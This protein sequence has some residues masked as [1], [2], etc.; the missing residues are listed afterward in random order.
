MKGVYIM[1]EIQDG[2]QNE[3]LIV[4]EFNNKKVYNYTSLIKIFILYVIINLVILWKN[5]KNT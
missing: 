5:G 3:F 1:V 2:Y 4:L